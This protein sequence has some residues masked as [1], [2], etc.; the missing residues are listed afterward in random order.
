MGKVI[1]ISGMKYGRLTVIEFSEMRKGKSFWLCR[2]D[3]GNSSVIVG[4]NL[5]NGHSES[6]GCKRLEDKTFRKTIHGMSKT[7]TYSVWQHMVER[8]NN[9][10]NK[11]YLNYGGRGIKVCDKWLK[12]NG[13]YEDM[14]DKPEGLT[15]DRKD[16]DGNY[17]KDNCRWATMKTQQ[18]NRTNNHVITFLGKTKTLMQWAE[19]IGI[20]Y[21]VLN[22]RINKHGWSIERALTTRARLKNIR[23]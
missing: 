7:K 9:P 15:L 16:S 20:K 11:R 6:C 22:D 13:F 19:E 23:S 4:N 8:C 2:C 17:C 14:G 3:C 5:K 10:K 21:K 12:F 18:N 1:D